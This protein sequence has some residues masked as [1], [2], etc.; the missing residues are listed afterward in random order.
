MCESNFS[1]IEVS[2]IGIGAFSGVANL[3]ERFFP[4]PRDFPGKVFYFNRYVF[5]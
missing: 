2:E 4:I 1:E 3:I 5:G